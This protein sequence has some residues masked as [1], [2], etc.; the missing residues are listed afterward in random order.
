MTK[1]ELGF[2]SCMLDEVD[3][4]TELGFCSRGYEVGGAV[5]IV[6]ELLGFGSTCSNL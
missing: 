1:I 2:C 4:K 5:A 6:D 3:M